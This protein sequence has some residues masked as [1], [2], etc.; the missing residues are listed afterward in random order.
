MVVRWCVGDLQGRPEIDPRERRPDA[1]CV[2]DGVGEDCS[3]G[4]IDLGSSAAQI[5]GGVWALVERRRRWVSWNSE[6]GSGL[7]AR[8]KLDCCDFNGIVILHCRCY[9]GNPR[10]PRVD[11]G[12]PLL[13]GLELQV[14][15]LWW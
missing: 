6:L 7:V 9:C 15:D 11:L 2:N 10:K 4:R 8:R 13:L 3:G 12:T 1:A 14:T 5:L